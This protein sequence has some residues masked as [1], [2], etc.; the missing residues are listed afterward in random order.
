MVL[1]TQ[2]PIEYE[3]TFPCPRRSSIALC[4]AFAWATPPEAQEILI[5]DRQQYVHPVEEIAKVVSVEELLA[6]QR[7]VKDIYL[8]ELVKE[9]IVEVVRRTREHPDVYLGAS[10]RGALALY[11]LGQARAALLGP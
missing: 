8:D 6:A 9:Y 11:R 3:G 7:A 2:N 10:S 1:A 4:C 5:L